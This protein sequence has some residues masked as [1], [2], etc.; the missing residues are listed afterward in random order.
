MNTHTCPKCHHVFSEPDYD[1]TDPVQRQGR[2]DALWK[3]SRKHVPNRYPEGSDEYY[4]WNRG[5]RS[6][7]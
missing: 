4:R 2:E 5:V 6:V 3:G 1:E 7:K